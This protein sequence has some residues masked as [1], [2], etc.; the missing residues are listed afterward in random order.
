MAQWD[1][2]LCRQSD[3]ITVAWNPSVGEPTAIQETV[4]DNLSDVALTTN[5]AKSVVSGSRKYTYA[6][7]GITAA[8]LVY[9]FD[10]PH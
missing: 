9:W 7:I 6:P 1:T 4:L 3:P 5:P 10:D 2:G 8:A